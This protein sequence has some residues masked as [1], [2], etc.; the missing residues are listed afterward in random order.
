MRFEIQSHV[1]ADILFGLLFFA[2][3]GNLFY[4]ALYPRGYEQCEILAAG[5]PF[6]YNSF[7][8]CVINGEVVE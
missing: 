4:H 3:V 2:I 6:S 8:G 7:G 5:E 1:V